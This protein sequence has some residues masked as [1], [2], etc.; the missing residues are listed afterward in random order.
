M[1]LLGKPAAPS[2]RRATAQ[3]MFHAPQQPSPITACTGVVMVQW[4]RPPHDADDT[5]TFGI[6]IQIDPL[7]I[8][9]CAHNVVDSDRGFLTGA[10]A[11]AA[12][13]YPG[14][15]DPKALT[16]KVPVLC[17]FYHSSY[18][19]ETRAWDIALLRLHEPLDATLP[20]LAA[21]GA[22]AAMAPKSG[23][24]SRK[25]ELHGYDA[26]RRGITISE[27]NAKNNLLV[28]DAKAI[29]GASGSP[30]YSGDT[31]YGIHTSEGN[32]SFGV[33]LFD[34]ILAWI[35]D[36]TFLVKPRIEFV[37]ALPVPD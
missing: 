32:Y 23:W 22:L 30:I 5:R 25:M 27:F 33:G 24:A 18:A 13:F 4:N 8:L 31:I 16:R 37:T 36:I 35:R 26:P 28:H 7:W 2:A 6:G 21:T 9:T 15:V 14:T 17:A 20:Q 11:T 19:E 1:A 10:V 12:Q 3:A 34:P 29:K